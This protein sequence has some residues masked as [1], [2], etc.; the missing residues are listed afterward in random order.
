MPL[1]S[2]RLRGLQLWVN[3][4]AAAK[5][6]APHYRGLVSR[7]IPV[8]PIGDGGEARVI[9]G[10]VGGVR[11][12]VEGLAVEA[13]YL[14]VSLA[15]RGTLR[16]PLPPDQNVFAYVF[17]GGC[18]FGT[19]REVEAGHMAV[20]GSGEELAVAAGQSGAR[21]LLIQ[22][23]PLREPVAWGGPIVM[24]TQEELRRAF[25]E[26]EP[27]RSSGSAVGRG[28]RPE[29][30]MGEGV[31]RLLSQAGPGVLRDE[32]AGD[33]VAGSDLPETGFLLRGFAGQ[34]TAPL[35]ID[36]AARTKAAAGA[37]TFLLSQLPA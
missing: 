2:G 34:R 14:D 9:A 20:L 21:F 17:E 22:G 24:N 15:P 13:A 7:E 37:G 18:R 23:R 27:G 25:E 31:L 29:L 33:L 3:L 36:R 35:E 8:V 28:L 6:S 30:K 19:S 26:F 12:A 4:P 16:E 5:M 10:D 32:V 11:G 1:R